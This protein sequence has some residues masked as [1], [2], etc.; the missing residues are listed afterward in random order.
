MKVLDLKRRSGAAAVDPV[1]RRRVPLELVLRQR[2]EW[3]P[4]A[5][6]CRKRGQGCWDHSTLLGTETGVLP[7]RGGDRR[8]LRCHCPLPS[9]ALARCPGGDVVIM[10]A[11]SGMWMLQMC[12]V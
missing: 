10:P 12:A 9:R 4:L 1:D 3:T 8:V 2:V 5:W 7:S 11:L 6:L